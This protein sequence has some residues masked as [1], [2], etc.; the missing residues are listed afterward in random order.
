MLQSMKHRGP[1]STGYALYAEPTENVVMRYTTANTT[2]PR[3]FE[4]QDRLKR[5]RAEAE[6]RLAGLGAKIVTCDQETDYAFR[7]TLEY[8]GDLK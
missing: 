8:T 2:T 3:D 4:F 7:L 5:N 6:R 1:D